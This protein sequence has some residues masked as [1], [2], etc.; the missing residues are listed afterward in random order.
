M[1]FFVVKLLNHFPVKGGVSAQY[2]PKTIMSGQTLNYKQCS[3][4]F[5]TYCQVHEEDGPRN[6]L[7]ARTQGAISLGPSSNRQG[8][9]LFYSLTTARVIARRSWTVLPTPQS[10]INRVNELA[11]DQPRLI[12]FADRHGNDI[13][14]DGD[15]E[16]NP[17][18]TPHEIPGVIGDAAQIPGVEMEMEAE[19]TN[20]EKNI[21]DPTT[22][23]IPPPIAEDA[24]EHLIETNDDGPNFEPTRD[25]ST[26]V[27]TAVQQTP[28]ATA[29]ISGTT[30][31][32]TA[33]TRRSTRTKSAVKSYV[34]SMTGKS[35]GY[36]ATQIS[37]MKHDPRVVE[38][39]LTQLTLNAAIKMW[40]DKA[41]VTAEAEMKQLH[42]RNSFRPVRWS[43]LTD[44]QRQTVLESHIFMKQKRTGEIKGRTVAGGNK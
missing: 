13:A 17:P 6:S 33:G 12:T 29:P 42:W 43:E 2:S 8:G 36:S 34:P 11:A 44:K 32:T 39:I 41:K 38:F 3:L 10:V 24:A 9:Q 7:A 16:I 19:Q 15:V 28:T 26:P 5:G 31:S 23:P 18:E 4:P 1:V 30:A 37:N 27:E 35:Y 21:N 22:T 25:D 14:D 40:G 20:D